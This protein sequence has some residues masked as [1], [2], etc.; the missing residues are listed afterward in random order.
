M[1]AAPAFGQRLALGVKGGVRATDDFL[2]GSATSESKRYVVGPMVEIVLPH[3]LG[4]EVNALYRRFGYRSGGQGSPFADFTERNRGNSWEFPMLLKYRFAGR[5]Y[6]AGGYAPRTINGSGRA[7]IVETNILAG[8]PRLITLRSDFD[9]VSH[10]AVVG[11]GV[12]LGSERVR[13]SPEFRYTRW[14]DKAV[15]IQGSR[16]FMIQSNQNQID[17]LLGIT[18]R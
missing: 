18:W 11:A 5:L 6:A 7:D 16:G 8:S 2:S 17:V 4:L 13:F 14:K 15:D 1:A 9:Y 12:E 3:R 10:G